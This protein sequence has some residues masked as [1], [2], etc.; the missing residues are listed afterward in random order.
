M[1]RVRM[2]RL[3]A[4]A[5]L[6]AL[7]AGCVQD[8][9][10]AV[11]EPSG[12]ARGVLV[13]P[14]SLPAGAVAQVTFSS[15]GAGGA[16]S[17]TEL[18]SSSPGVWQ[19]LLRGLPSG[20]YT[21]KATASDAASTV[22]FETESTEAR[23]APS[24]PALIILVEQEPGNASGLA[25]LI[26]SVISS[27]AAVPPGR[28]VTLRAQV[29]SVAPAQVPS[30]QWEADG[31]TF[32]DPAAQAP[33]WTAPQ[34]TGRRTLRLVVR[35]PGGAA[36]SL[37]FT[38]D[39]ST[40]REVATD[41]P[42][43][44]NRWPVGENPRVLPSKNVA[45]GQQVTAEIQGTDA[46][47]DALTYTWSAD[48][49]G[50]LVDS[51]SPAARFS[52]SAVPPASTCD[53][54]RLLVSIEDAYGGRTE[55][56][57]GLCIRAPLPP[58]IVSTSAVGPTARPGDV[59]MMRVEAV[60]P[61][62]GPLTFA[63]TLSTG[64]LGT[65][66]RTGNTSEVPWTVLSCIPAGVTPTLEATVTNTFGL[67]ASQR[68][69]V[70][71]NGPVCGH[72]PC[73]IRLDQRTLTAQADCVTDT[74]VFIP[75]GYNLDGAEHTLTAV[76]PVGG[77]FVGA[78]MRNRGSRADVSH[79]KLRAQGLLKSGPCDADGDRLRGILLQDVSGSVIDSEV[80][81]IH[82]NQPGGSDPEGVPRGCQEGHAIEVRN[83]DPATPRE[84]QVLRNQVS[85][86]Q[87]VGILVIGKVN[88][89]ITGNVVNGGGPVSHIARNGMQLSDG[90]TGR[91]TGNQV[92]GHSFTGADVAT[93]ILVAGGPYYNQAL[94]RD[95]VI[96]GNILTNNDI[97]VYLSQIEADGSPPVAPTRIQVVG[98]TLSNDAVTNGY[99]F[100]AGI[101]D[102]GSGNIISSNVI[103]GPGYDPATQPGAT[104][105]VDVLADAESQ[106]AFLTAPE[107]VA[108]QACSGR[109]VVQSQDAKGNLVK[110][111]QTLFNLAASGAAAP[112]FV[113]YSDAGCQQAITTVD[114]GS[115]QAEA[116]FYF[117][118]VRTGTV[119]ITVSNGS[120][121]GLQER[122]ISGP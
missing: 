58:T 8:Y 81:D 60:D 87:K 88:A 52:P 38:I 7:A 41:G 105:D 118:A 59:L 72:P 89:T 33:V 32:D 12:S 85:G 15:A 66:V 19:G 106:V 37:S 3:V 73:E 14:R 13:L 17:S 61:L 57:L 30:Y 31:G 27:T 10:P 110:P 111:A 107:P 35:D 47:G 78:I 45:A 23:L 96:E 36:A 39:V 21:F 18:T 44:F 64:I 99:V 42:V 120:L 74:P 34:E 76:D 9:P 55:A 67:S 117:K 22:R 95:G 83:T 108:A 80:L 100:Q 24:R 114:L 104:F 119:S 1:Y 50:T 116:V 46:D 29:S 91:V 84:V 86:Y 51:S 82:R 112:G 56:A 97:G 71:W 49:Q 79:L 40:G 109:V 115:P 5:G 77:H 25:P 26:H 28:T 122:T 92:S 54:C 20:D 75:D 101:S 90:A 69:D 4:L 2:G 11:L 53:N 103:S 16:S 70:T 48:C 102:Y 43:I 68:F 6:L 98:N 65:A 113:F 93:G 121:S 63:W 62:G 94:S